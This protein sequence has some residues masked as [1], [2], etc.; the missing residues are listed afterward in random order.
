MPKPERKTAIAIDA[1]DVL[2][3][4]AEA[5]INFSNSNYGTDFSLEDYHDNWPEL[6]DITHEEM[7][8]RAK[9]FHTTE[10]VAEY[11]LINEADAAIKSLSERYRLFVVT[12]RPKYNIE[13]TRQWIDRHFS[14]AFDGIHFVPIWEINNQVTKAD[15]C[16]Q[17][18]ADYL[19]DDLARHC[20]VAAEAGIKALL[21]GDYTWNR[22]E[23]VTLSVVR[24]KD[25]KEVLR[26]FEKS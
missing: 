25:W 18:G 20:N 22:N 26:Y 8:K 14:G 5:F 19:I 16:R 11:G 15:I 10:S 21:F 13:P 6:W 3:G 9:K 12:A 23:P 17:I 24:V 4:H 2:A 1:D 7:E